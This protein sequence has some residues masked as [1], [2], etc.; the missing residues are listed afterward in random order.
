MSDTGPMPPRTS[1]DPVLP[2]TLSRP[3][4]EAAP[5]IRFLAILMFVGVGFMILGSFFFFALALPAVSE[6]AG[7]AGLTPLYG[8]G[9][10]VLYIML[11]VVMFFPALYCYR[12]GDALKNWGNNGSVSE[13][14][15]AFRNNKAFWKFYGIVTLIYLGLLALGLVAGLVAVLV[16]LAL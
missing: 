9:M 3:L 10:G 1:D 12:Y 2:E 6:L 7:D 13:L 14:A 4:K 16:T 15:T 11:A 5:W 8:A